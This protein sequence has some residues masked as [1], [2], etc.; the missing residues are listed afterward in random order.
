MQEYDS[1]IG[2][3]LTWKS[4]G[5]Q[6]I[7]TA[8]TKFTPELR[9]CWNY[10]NSMEVQHGILFKHSYSTDAQSSN[11]QF[12]VPKAMRSKCSTTS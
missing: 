7:G 1:D 3:I 2:P 12:I 10:W 9:D 11:L 8:T 4:E 6:P 5:N